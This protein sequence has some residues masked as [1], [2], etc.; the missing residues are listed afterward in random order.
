MNREAFKRKLTAVFS[1]DVTGYSRLMNADESSTVLT[2]TRYR[3]VMATL[4]KQHRGRVVDSP[5]DNVL[6]EFV[7]V[8][9]A[10][11]CAVAVQKEI[12]ARNADLAEDRRMV[13]R[14]GI[15]LGD[16]IE[17]GKRIYG[18][19]VNIAAR[20]ESM[21]DP[22]GICISRTAF[23][24]IESKLPLGYEYLGEKPVK[25]IP[26]PVGAY[27][28]LMEPKIA[29]SKEA[30]M[31][32]AMLTR[33][34]KII[35]ATALCLFSL[36][37]AV[38]I[39]KHYSTSP[40]LENTA[41]G[42]EGR[43]P[44]SDKPALAVLPFVDMSEDSEQAYF[45]DGITE[46]II[47]ALSAIPKLSVV[48]RNSTFAYKGKPTNIQQVGRELGARYILEGSVQREGDR[49]RI[50]AQLIDAGT[51][52][53][54]WVERYDREFKDIFA[55]QDEIVLKIM[56]SLQLTL[57]EG[58]R[59]S[60]KGNAPKSLDAYLKF[61][62]GRS[63]F[64]RPSPDNNAKARQLFEE[65]IALDPTY[66]GAYRTLARTHLRDVWYGWSRAPRESLAR[67][68]TSAEKS[69]ILDS[70]DAGAHARLSQI[71]LFKGEHEKAVSEAERA[72]A[73]SPNSVEGYGALGMSLY[74]DG[75]YEEAVRLLE[76]AIGLEP[77]P[78]TWLLH[79]L[80]NGYLMAG[81]Y[82]DAIA[83]YGKALDRNPKSLWALVGLAAAY[84][85]TGREK[86]ARGASAA[87]LKAKP[88]FSLDYLESMLP[89]KNQADKERF[90]G[91]LREAGLDRK[92][93]DAGVQE[94]DGSR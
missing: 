70:S 31:A 64:Q 45:S 42:E 43:P 51:G 61:L 78:A 21:A 13:F 49:V 29:V 94:K 81:Q 69:L 35:L 74:Y 58:Q 93:N 18:D 36:M 33:R 77:V 87:L 86:E 48:A 68:M 10:V 90:V 34:R 73:L 1:A 80:G 25:N 54:M 85:M 52:H 92:N 15:N 11:Q 56:R 65:A 9:D 91:A 14:I 89:Y 3:D 17:E 72:L 39:W 12:Q 84:G 82:A 4:V 23:D 28:V 71:Y 66:S 47:T 37:L 46:D 50:T 67:A 30:K 41:P 32:R 7:S 57:S 53:H 76:K 5:G 22:G 88:L 63:Y 20:L 26:R 83:A 24:Q 19:G 2:I 44:L 55:L 60:I 38:G 79:N 59:H 40:P 62:K 6:A 27:R 8:V 75:R 16:V